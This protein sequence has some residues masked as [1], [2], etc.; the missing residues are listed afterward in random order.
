MSVLKQSIGSR[1]KF[2]KHKY[3]NVSN[4]A[5]DKENLLKQISDEID[6]GL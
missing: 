6:K 5:F 2:L 3:K 1:K 4:P